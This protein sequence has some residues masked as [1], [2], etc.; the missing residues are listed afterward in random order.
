MPVSATTSTRRAP[1]PGRWRGSPWIARWSSGCGATP[2]VSPRSGTTGSNTKAY[3]SPPSL[4]RDLGRRRGALQLGA[5]RKRI[6]HRRR[7]PV[8]PPA[9]D[10]RLKIL[11][12]AAY[13]GTD[14]RAVRDYLMSFRL[15]SRHDYYYVFDCR[16]LPGRMDLSPFDAILIFWHVDLLGP[17]L[18]ASLREQIA[19]A[20]GLKVV[21]RQD[22]YRDI[23]PVNRAM[24]E[25]G[26]Q[27][28][29][30]CTAEADHGIFYPAA[31]IPQLEG[32]YTV[33]PGYVPRYLEEVSLDLERSRP[34]DVGYRSRA[35]PFHLGDLGQEKAAVAERFQTLGPPAGLIMDISIQERDRLYGRRWLA[36]LKSCRAV[37]GTSSGASVADFTGGIRRACAR[38]LAL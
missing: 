31:A 32:I 28:V 16:A 8:N 30:T 6:A 10:E 33:L 22:E 26:T 29:L 1:S 25:I 7:P 17:D 9:T 2:A 19:R 35:M 11:V 14:A 4:P 20:P 37:L 12:L 15:H 23:E 5:I 21:I 38:Y 13:D 34:I 18:P 24:A 36:F 27:V 3:C